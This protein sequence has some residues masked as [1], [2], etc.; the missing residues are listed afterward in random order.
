MGVADS[1]KQCTIYGQGGVKKSNCGCTFWDV[2]NDWGVAAFGIFAEHLLILSL[3]LSPS[4]C[5]SLSSQYSATC[6]QRWK[7]ERKKSKHTDDAISI[8]SAYQQTQSIWDSLACI[9]DVKLLTLQNDSVI[10]Q[11]NSMLLQMP[12]SGQA[13][14]VF[15]LDRFRRFDIEKVC[16]HLWGFKL[17]TISFAK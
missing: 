11:N 6:E 16:A 9:A 2:L 3:S 14:D 10:T 8:S 13:W 7:W 12:P 1:Q 4:L 15:P 5:V 17:F